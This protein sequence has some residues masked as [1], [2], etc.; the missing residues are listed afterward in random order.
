MKISKYENREQWLADRRGK[1]TGSR[2]KDIIVKRGTK[3]KIGF[4]ELIAEKLS[5]MRDGEKPMDRGTRLEEEAIERFCQ[6]TNKKVNTDLVIW[7]RDDNNAIAISPDGYIET[8]EGLIT[9]AVECKCLASSRHIEAWLTKEVPSDYE[10]QVIQYFIVNDTLTTLYFVFYDPSIPTKDFFYFT[11]TR[12][13]IQDKVSEYLEYQ[14]R[15]LAEVD[16]IV[17]DLTF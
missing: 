10:E 2:L 5:V 15:V 17:N 9:E 11:V 16:Q 1:V 13:D 8:A 14:K 3:Q 12:T 4:Y 7:S 6:E